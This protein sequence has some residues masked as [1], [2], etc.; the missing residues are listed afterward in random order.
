MSTDLQSGFC[1]SLLSLPVRSL[2]T[3]VLCQASLSVT[4]SRS[5]LKL[6]STSQQCQ[7]TLSSSVVTSLFIWL[8]S[9]VKTP[10]AKLTPQSS[11]GIS[12]SK[13]ISSYAAL[14]VFKMFFIYWN[15][16]LPRGNGFSEL[17]QSLFYIS[18]T[19]RY[20]DDAG[21]LVI[22][23]TTSGQLCFLLSC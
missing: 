21:I 23:T 13:I 8:L 7:P 22:S 9:T 4:N 14:R 18:I 16:T 11:F 12:H 3:C 5:L 20:Q 2:L 17:T 10:P 19:S 6:V 15:C 1:C